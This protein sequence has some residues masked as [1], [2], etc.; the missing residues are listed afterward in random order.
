[1]GR[2]QHYQ[3]LI[4]AAL[5]QTIAA[6]PAAA[7][8]KRAAPVIGNSAYVNAGTQDGGLPEAGSQPKQRGVQS[9]AVP[10]KQ[11]IAEL[12]ALAA[13]QDWGELHDR[14]KEVNPASR[15]AH[16]KSLVEQ[17]AIGELE[18]LTAPGGS[19]E[20][21]LSALKRYYPKFPSLKTS[22]RFQKLRTKIGLDAFTLCFRPQYSPQNDKVK[23][24]QNDNVQCLQSNGKCL[25]ELEWFVRT[26]PLSVDLAAGA[27]HI[28]D[29]HVNHQLPSV[30]YSVALDAPGGEAVCTDSKLEFDLNS[31]LGLPPGQREA[32][33]ARAIT[34]RC[35]H[36]VKTI[37]AAANAR[38][39]GPTPYLQNACPIL[40]Q[41]KALTGLKEN[42][43]QAV[44]SEAAAGK[45][46]T[47]Q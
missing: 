34:E 17:A 11:L 43:C 20:E 30:F 23:C 14:L 35:F 22:A 46:E 44:V 38:E 1:M 9:S 45:K 28:V 6:L 18:P 13:A 36:V 12:D 33:A 5:L 27:A 4:A 16:W 26:A 10:A 19:S 42:R 29:E 47:L 8:E 3:L 31:A 15:D 40:I 25:S 41:H 2:L 39:E 37:V 21:R 7:T 32:Q 24:P